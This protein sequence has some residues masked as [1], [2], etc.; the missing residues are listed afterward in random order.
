MSKMNMAQAV[1]NAIFLEMERDPN[2]LLLGE[3]VGAPGGVLGV[4]QGLY[5]KF[6]AKRVI[7]TPISESAFLGAGVGAAAVGLRRIWSP[8][9]SCLISTT[10]F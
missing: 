8:G 3:D 1:N 6:G 10:H 2:V 9:P 5:A 4:T 7:D